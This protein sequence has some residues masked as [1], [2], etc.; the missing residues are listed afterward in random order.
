MSH[1]CHTDD[2]RVSQGRPDDAVAKRHTS[3]Q[4]Q[5]SKVMKTMIDIHSS[6]GSRA[7]EQA[8]LST[9]G[10]SF[11][12]AYKLAEKN[13]P[14][15]CS[16]QLAAL[17]NLALYYSMVRQ[18]KKAEC[19]YR[20]ALKLIPCNEKN[21]LRAFIL[22]RLAEITNAQHKDKVAIRFF[23]KA[24]YAYEADGNEVHLPLL[25]RAYDSLVLLCIAHEKY[26]KAERF[27]LRAFKSKVQN[28]EARGSSR[29]KAC[30]LALVY[31]EMKQFDR[32]VQTFLD[33]R[34]GAWKA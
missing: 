19:R 10:K 13:H 26:A 9:A 15:N 23:E 3:E 12:Q 6:Q 22:H 30:R 32:A 28:F 21:P 18:W 33:T 14:S 27:S 7:F 25:E 5:V 2:R 29:K 11:L 1:A 31:A 20:A 34:N 17:W 24:I 4:R 8:D 16:Q